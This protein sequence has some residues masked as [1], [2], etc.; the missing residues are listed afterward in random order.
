MLSRDQLILSS[1]TVGN[2]SLEELLTAAR[3]GGYG[4]VVLWGDSWRR[5]RADG[6]T[7]AEARKRFDESGIRVAQ[8]D[9]LLRWTSGSGSEKAA[10]EER[11]LFDTAGAF[12]AGC[13]S[14]F[15]PGDD[16]Y[17]EASLAATLAGV[18]DRAADQGLE[19][20]LEVTPWRSPVDLPAAIRLLSLVSRPNA[21][22]II[23]SW[24]V[25]RGPISLQQLR[26]LPGNLVAAVQISDAPR[27]PAADLF[28]ETMS[29]R[30][31]PGQG[32]IDLAA[33]VGTL[34]AKVDNLAATVEVLSDELLR[35]GP[36]ESAR[37][38]AD[39]TRR[40]LAGVRL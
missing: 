31:L 36:V 24:H 17:P 28:A 14:V 2:P 25:F 26:Q 12:G 34:D 21:G 23:D 6:I 22:L 27:D 32:T 39:A 16:R 7:D 1:G 38:A 3:A 13:I 5:W 11:D 9:G 4:A 15:S 10:A 35:A 29:Q 33:F 37:R 18:C 8:L 19:I 20:V 30:L 40:L